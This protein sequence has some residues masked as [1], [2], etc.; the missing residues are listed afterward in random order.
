M[1]IILF[2]LIVFSKCGNKQIKHILSENVNSSNNKVKVQKTKNNASKKSTKEE[3]K[4]KQAKK[5]KKTSKPNQLKTLVVMQLKDK[6][7][8]SF[9]KNKKQLLRKIVFSILKFTVVFVIAFVILYLSIYLGLFFNSDFPIVMVVV[10]TISLLL[11]LISCTYEL[12]T[13][14]FFAEDNRVLITLPVNA[15]KIF[16]S[17]IIVFYIYELKKALSFLIPIILSCVTLLVYRGLGNLWLFLWIIIPLFFILML[18]VLI[19]SL[20][21]ILAM[22][23]RRFLKKVPIIQ[24]ILFLAILVGV[25]ALVVYLINLIPD[26]ISLINQWPTISKNIRSFFIM[27]RSKLNI[28]AQLVYILIGEYSHKGLYLISGMTLVKLLVL[29]AICAVL[30][31]LVYFISRPIYFG[32]MSKNFEINKRIGNDK[33]NKRK[34]KY[35][36]FVNKEFKINLRTISISINYLMV[37]IIVPIMILFLNKMYKAMETSVLGDE[38]IY[39]FNILLI[40]LPLLASNGLVATYYSREGRAGYIKKTKPINAVYPLFVK[41]IFNMIFS[42]PSVFVTCFVFGYQKEFT[43]LNSFIL[44]MAILFLHY[45]HMI[46]SATLD[47]MNPQNE[48]YATTGDNIDNPNEN[49]STIF[50]FIIS[51]I[52]TIIAYKLLSETM[53]TGIV[54]GL[55]KMLLISAAFFASTLFMFIKRIKAFY[56]EI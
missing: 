30:I 22:Y 28:M 19:G 4:K 49:K 56:Y 44:S 43:I 14:L 35:I 20:L 34:N 48:Q 52:Y 45:G 12:T 13:N 40:C 10:V 24:I 50:A 23:I 21:S 18:P 54:V 9:A 6:I 8:F 39:T 36:T 46:Y 27:V 51:A 26:N 2:L 1:L 47:I 42:L 31:L 5:A 38:L 55:I 37:Y 15:N 16:I 3:N 7:D 29:I 11:S 17:R 33:P 41:I 32:M 25:V 53:A